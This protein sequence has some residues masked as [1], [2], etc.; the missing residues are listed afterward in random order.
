LYGTQITDEGLKELAELRNLAQLDLRFCKQL[1]DAGV[2]ELDKALP[3]VIIDW[4]N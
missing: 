3:G 2:T 4:P 1:T